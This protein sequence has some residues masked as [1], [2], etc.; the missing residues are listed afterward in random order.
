MDT[1][2]KHNKIRNFLIQSQKLGLVEKELS[3]EDVDINTLVLMLFKVSQWRL[4]DENMTNDFKSLL[5]EKINFTIKE[6]ADKISKLYSIEKYKDTVPEYYSEISNEIS[7][8]QKEI[9]KLTNDL[10][11]SEKTRE[12]SNYGNIR[13]LLGRI[14]EFLEITISIEREDLKRLNTDK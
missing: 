1:I 12:I 10:N 6:R 13:E 5:R 4:S 2:T 7:S 11:K 3:I 14:K 9:D 8:L